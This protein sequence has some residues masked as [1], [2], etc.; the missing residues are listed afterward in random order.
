MLSNYLSKV[1]ERLCEIQSYAEDVWYPHIKDVDLIAWGTITKE[2]VIE[3]LYPKDHKPSK[4]FPY[5]EEG[6]E[7]LEKF[8]ESLHRDIETFA[9]TR[10]DKNVN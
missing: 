2:N 3:L 5:T 9:E 4:R 7:R 6:K 1:N 8:M 10:K